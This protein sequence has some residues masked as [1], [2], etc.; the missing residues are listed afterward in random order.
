M[1]ILVLAGDGI[2]A[3]VTEQAVRVVQAV[4]GSVPG[5]ELAHAPIGADALAPRRPF[6]LPHARACTKG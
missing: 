1:K 5:F 2:G 4:A 3:E 6:A